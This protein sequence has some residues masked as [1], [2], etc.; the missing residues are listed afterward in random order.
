MKYMGDDMNLRT[1]G[2][3][4]GIEEETITGENVED[5]LTVKEARQFDQEIPNAETRGVLDPVDNSP[6]DVV[7]N[8]AEK[9]MDDWPNVEVRFGGLYEPYG[10]IHEMFFSMKTWKINL[11]SRNT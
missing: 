11:D 3:R 1:V 5:A 9:I 10:Y 8:M 2:S 7:A 4:F 6:R